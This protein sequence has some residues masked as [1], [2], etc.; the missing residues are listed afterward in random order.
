M[1][2]EIKPFTRCSW[3]VVALRVCILF[4]IVSSR[5]V[6]VAAADEQGKLL[7]TE[8]RVEFAR[9][10]AEWLPAVINQQLES[11]DRVRTLALS[12]AMVQLAELGRMRLDELTT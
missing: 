5:L 12:R 9:H 4:G 6:P 7:S 11:Q 10:S 2:K 3:S 1:L 8:G